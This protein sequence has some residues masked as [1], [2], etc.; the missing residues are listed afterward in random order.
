LAGGMTA[1][2]G[3]IE[4]DMETGKHVN[5]SSL[6]TSLPVDKPSKLAVTSYIF[7][8]SKEFSVNHLLWRDNTGCRTFALLR[9]EGF[10]LPTNG[11]A[12]KAGKP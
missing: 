9:L 11:R 5:S 7:R 4:M 6:A 1:I 12:R 2:I 3:A 8:K 10:P